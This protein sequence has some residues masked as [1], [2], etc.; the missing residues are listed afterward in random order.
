MKYALLSVVV[1][2]LIVGAV[3]W[4][5]MGPNNYAKPTPK[6]RQAMGVIALSDDL[7]ALMQP[8]NPQV[9]PM[10]VLDR[11]NTYWE[12]VDEGLVDHAI[13]AEQEDE[14]VRLLLELANAGDLPQGF[15]DDDFPIQPMAQSLRD[16]MVGH[17][18]TYFV[19]HVD[20]LRQAGE[21]EQAVALGLALWRLSDQV[22]RRNASVRSRKRGIMCMRASLDALSTLHRFGI[23]TGV[24]EEDLTAWQTAQKAYQFALVYKLDVVH[25]A[26]PRLGDLLHIAGHDADS[27]WRTE[28]MLCIA[29]AQFAPG[30]EANIVRMKDL[31]DQAV[32]SDDPRL[33]E[34]GQLAQGYTVEDMR[35][36]QNAARV[37]R[38]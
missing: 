6:M 35:Q 11:M 23:E 17:F 36:M 25:R 3:F 28:A 20:T 5:A 15:L 24:S 16:R 8:A 38:P 4:L 19:P 14:G 37:S 7:P 10:D 29:Y 31:M 12:Q 34:A 33:V 27:A 26:E 32:A 13:T 21:D 30:T 22:V 18:V 2:A 1:F 9:N